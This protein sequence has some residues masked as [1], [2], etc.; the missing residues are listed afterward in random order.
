VVRPGD[1]RNGHQWRKV[2]G[3]VLAHSDLCH[4]CRHHDAKTVD[5][6]ISVDEWL[7]RY[8]TTEGVNHISNLAP[9]H[10]TRGPLPPNRCPTCKRLC[11]QAKGAGRAQPS[12]R[13]RR[14]G[15]E[16]KT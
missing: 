13:S 5:H 16:S 11:N 9:A 15:L 14:W 7:T 1:P 2:C 8:G 3:L 6:I 10:G 4:L 12:P